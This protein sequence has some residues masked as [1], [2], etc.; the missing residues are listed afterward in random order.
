MLKYQR[1]GIE[2]EYSG[3]TPSVYNMCYV[4]RTVDGAPCFCSEAGFECDSASVFRQ[5]EIVSTPNIT[6]FVKDLRCEFHCSCSLAYRKSF[7]F[8]RHER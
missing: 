7:A 4:S 6:R 8:R 2:Y 3:Y 1:R 5:D